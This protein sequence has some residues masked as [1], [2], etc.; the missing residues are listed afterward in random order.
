VDD[1][2]TGA[3]AGLPQPVDADA[4]APAATGPLGDLVAAHFQR[5][6]IAMLGRI[7]TTTLLGALPASMVR[8]ERRRTLLDRLRRRSGVV[9]GVGVSAGDQL[10]SFRAPDV[11]VTQASVGHIVGGVVLSSR[12]VPVAEWLVLLG[13]LLEQATTDDGATRLAL[14]RALL[15]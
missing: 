9:V 6:E 2:D 3:E 1:A 11:G 15:T 7:L 8:V 4:A 14:E 13:A 5:V 12:P 10:L